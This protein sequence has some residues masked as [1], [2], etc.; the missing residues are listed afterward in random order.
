MRRTY[1]CFFFALISLLPVSACAQCKDQL[2]SKIQDILDGATIDFRGY[3]AHTV[4]LPDVS[5]E[6]AKVPCSTSTWA[7]NVPMLICFAQIPLGNATNWYARTMDALKLLS[8]TSWHFDVK[9][10]G[11][12]HYVYAGPPD[13]EQPTPTEGPYIGQCPLHLEVFKQADGSAKIYL[14]V[15]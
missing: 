10:P 13:C 8:P 2:C 11:D 6:S 5:T 9:G 15:N 3:V 4:P 1:A 14:V 7:N 12:D